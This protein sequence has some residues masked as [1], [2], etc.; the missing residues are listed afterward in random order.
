[1]INIPHYEILEKLYES[2]RSLIYRAVRIKDK[3][4]AVLKVLRESFPA[5]E[6]V[7]FYKNE[8]EAAQKMV[9][10]GT[11]EALE[12]LEVENRP[13]IAFKDIGGIDLGQLFET[14][15]F[16]LSER[17][18][19]AVDIAEILDRIHSSGYIHQDIKPTNI[20]YNPDTHRLQIIDFGSANIASHL[21]IESES[22]RKLHGT[23]PY[24]SPEHTGRANRP[25]DRRSDLY[26]LGVTYYELF[27]GRLPFETEDLLEIVHSHIARTPQ[28]P[29][30][31]NSEIPRPLSDLI[32]KLLSK[33]PEHRYQSAHGVQ[34]DLE[35]CHGQLTGAGKIYPF[36]LAGHDVSGQFQIPKTIYGR[37]KEKERLLSAFRRAARGA[38]ELVLVHGASGIGKTALTLDIDRAIALENGVLAYG[39][40]EESESGASF[41]ALTGAFKELLQ[42]ILSE[43]PGSLNRW[44]ERLKIALGQSG[45]VILDSI[46][47][48]VLVLGRQPELEK[49]EPAAAH[50]RQ[51]RVFQSFLQVFCRPERPLVL[52]LDQVQWADNASLEFLFSLL[53]SK[54]IEFLLVVAAFRDEPT[55]AVKWVNE[56]SSAIREKGI[57]VQDIGLGPLSGDQAA[58]LVADT[59]HASPD[60]VEPLSELI[61]RKTGGNPF[62]IREFLRTLYVDRLLVFDGVKRFWHWDQKGVEAKSYT[63]N[64]LDLMTAN[65]NRLNPQTRETL[66]TASVMGVRF[67]PDIVAE[68]CGKKPEEVYQIIEEAIAAGL[69]AR[70]VSGRSSGQSMERFKFIHDRIQRT[71]Y[72]L[73]PENEK[74]NL[75]LS[76]GETLLKTAP[77]DE[78][79][80]RLLE[81]V[82]HLNKGAKAIS[83][84]SERLDL[85]RL[86]LEASRRAKGSGMIEAAYSCSKAGLDLAEDSLWTSDY[87]LMLELHLEKME[88]ASLIGAY[89]EM[90][91]LGQ[92]AMSSVWT[93]LEK[94]RI[95]QIRINALMVMNHWPEAARQAIE[96]LALLGIDLPE[97]MY[98]QMREILREKVM[99]ITSG[100]SSIEKLLDLPEMTDPNYLAAMQIMAKVYPAFNAVYSDR[101]PLLITE[102][103]RLSVVHGNAPA[104]ALA[105]IYFAIVLC[106]EREFEKAYKFG[107]MALDLARR[108]KDRSYEIYVKFVFNLAVRHWREHLSE[109]LAP[110][111]EVHKAGLE[112]G[113]FFQSTYALVY[114][115]VFIYL[116]G[117]PLEEADKELEDCG[118]TLQRL[119]QT[120]AFNFVW[121]F[122][123][124]IANLDGRSKDP[125]VLNGP[126]FDEQE[127]MARESEADNRGRDF[128]ICLGKLF[129]NM[130]FEQYEKALDF[131]K[132][133]AELTEG[134]PPVMALW[135]QC[136][137]YE[138]I[139]RI[140][141]RRR[142]DAPEM[143][144]EHEERIGQCMTHL[145]AWHQDAP[146]NMAQKHLL[147]KAELAR[148]N[149]LP[150]EAAELYDQAISAAKKN[151][152]LHDEALANELAARFYFDRGK[153]TIGRSYLLEAHYTYK[154]WGALAKVQQLEEKYSDI[155]SILLQGP[156]KGSYSVTR[157]ISPTTSKEADSLD[158]ASAFKAAQA[159]SG[160]IV[161]EKLIER[162]M[163]IIMENAGAEKGFLILE[164]DGRLAIEF[165]VHADQT[166][167]ESQALHP[168]EESPCLSA[169]I[170]NYAAHTKEVVLLEDAE[171]EG[172]FTTDP[173]I[174]KNRIKS[175]LC[176][177]LIKKDELAGVIYLENNLFPGAF[178][179]DH[180]EALNWLSTQAAI[181]LENAK[182]YQKVS[183]YSSWLE[184]IIAALNVAQEIQQSLLPDRPPRTEGIDIAGRS[185][186][187]DET[188]GDYFDF[189][190]LENPDRIAVVLGDVSGH[191]ISSALLMS[192]ARAYLRS[193]ALMPG[194][195]A[196][197]ITAVNRLV[198][199]DTEETGQ[200]MT[201]FY[202]EVSPA[203]R[204]LAWVRAGQDPAFI[205]SPETGEFDELGG[206]GLALGIDDE[207][208]Y[209]D[210]T[211]KAE[212]GQIVIL[213]TDGVWEARNQQGEMFGKDKFKELILRNSNLSA[214]GVIQAIIDAVS[215]YRGEAAQDDDI[216]LVVIKF[217]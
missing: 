156:E 208:E 84:E 129:L 112:T 174:I 22:S 94:V 206:P 80:N 95:L 87:E 151:K 63:D 193:R 188:G 131:I 81:I 25:V 202:L 14:R 20:I 127:I 17:I 132:G 93:D 90:E 200:F 61:I 18:R 163:S 216:T 107:R 177:P 29:M 19:L 161:L 26:S 23:Q 114:R 11:P 53:E 64:V 213:A 187:C 158:L 35:N 148:V 40:Y 170:V 205:F 130:L 54:E 171:N 13:V 76:I 214:E 153:I 6:D 209:Q 30:E 36:A 41:S 172:K 45:R 68:V 15:T 191:G 31:V 169:A 3:Q 73:I 147:A 167:F 121:L 210:R 124:F 178:T 50:T 201:L 194:S 146:M 86:N 181:S 9:T 85:A 152:Y 173:Y 168:L 180:F 58:R 176:L 113:D 184:G 195:P 136:V 155:L 66:Q 137:F 145:E 39:R 154:R 62:F 175:V 43:G 59:L 52:F 47:E 99:S 217:D 27:T 189:I 10:E 89:E 115:A 65:V 44:R 203:T 166:E 111:Y 55:P 51:V 116:M 198:S 157:S 83:T 143:R 67:D 92:T 57:G 1:M 120:D 134:T 139:T 56:R 179:T 69:V 185:L 215:V 204:R 79:S 91:M 104:S 102:M 160:E 96:A 105:Y 100:C 186:Y 211:L 8:F 88:T 141:L 2:P 82:H 159:L 108:F 149:E 16:T 12:Y 71:L 103:V 183:D 192:G 133:I 144:A 142:G 162:L 199:A 24:M 196:E 21:D 122:R 190:K 34:I 101:A 98:D 74:P 42:G 4:K 106:I 72:R 118:L 207:W 33:N 5:A 123:Q 140:T 212:A 110:F 49:L 128:G 77:E 28:T 7:E 32:M 119:G 182:L 164:R 125:S 138:A 78:R 37:D 60:V 165:S 135:T 97:A 197:V 70:H 38:R 117:R 75:H 109:T 126:Y 46:P 48:A 150:L